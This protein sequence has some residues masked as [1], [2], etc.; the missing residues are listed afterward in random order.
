MFAL[1]FGQGDFL[2]CLDAIIGLTGNAE[3]SLCLSTGQSHSGQKGHFGQI[4]IYLL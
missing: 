1:G 4:C 2:F 3:S